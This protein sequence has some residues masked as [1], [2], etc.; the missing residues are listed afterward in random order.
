MTGS[1][2]MAKYIVGFDGRWQ[3]TFEDR[4]EAIQWAEEVAATGRV[5]DVVLKRR[6]LPRKLLTA[7]PESERAARE[8]AW[9]IPWTSGGVVG[10]P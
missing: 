6:L 4:G 7:F 10:S 2:A 1:L 5:V 9:L 3:E 8:A